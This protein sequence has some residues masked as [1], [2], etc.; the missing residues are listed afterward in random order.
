MDYDVVVCGGTLGVFLALA[1]QQR[2]H[3]VAIV[4]RRLLEG[5]NQVCTEMSSIGRI[6]DRRES[7]VPSL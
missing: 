1:L 7:E 2:G 5:R 6:K 3:K 4:E